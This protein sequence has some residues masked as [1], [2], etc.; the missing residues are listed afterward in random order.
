MKSQRGFFKLP[1]QEREAIQV[2]KLQTSREKRV[3]RLKYL[4]SEAERNKRILQNCQ[5]SIEESIS[6]KTFKEEFQSDSKRT[7][8]E[9]SLAGTHQNS[10]KVPLS[11]K[12][13]P[14]ESKPILKID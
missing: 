10:E 3:M 14:E 7:L 13:Y 6:I 11:M 9:V 5:E 2:K 1:K 8:Q 12:N 4:E